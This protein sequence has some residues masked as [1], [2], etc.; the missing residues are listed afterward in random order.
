MDVSLFA[1]LI[2]E[3]LSQHNRVCLP[4]MG[5]FVAV[6]QPPKLIKKGRLI[7]APARAIVFSVKESW[8]DEWLEQ[9]FAAE[10]NRSMPKPEDETVAIRNLTLC[11]EQARREIAQFVVVVK[12]QFRKS[13]VFE[14]PGFGTMKSD[15]K[16]QVAFFQS[17][18]CSIDSQAFGL[19][20]LA[21][22]PLY[23]VASIEKLHVKRSVTKRATKSRQRIS[24]W[25]YAPLGVVLWLVMLIIMIFVFKE[26]LTPIFERLL[27]TPEERS[28]L[29]AQGDTLYET[30]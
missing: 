14:I 28:I 10:L 12:I 30:I 1:R 4:G 8:N 13:G 9:A 24:G 15:D 7:K 2:P 29:H 5:S 6:E 19:P 23:T 25:V 20:D 3:I 22:K 17:P 26:R 21:I 16:D 11:L 27:Y 18:D